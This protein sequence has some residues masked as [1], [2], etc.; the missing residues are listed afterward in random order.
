MAYYSIEEQETVIRYDSI[1]KQWDIYTTIPKHIKRLKN[2]A[3][4]TLLQEEKDSDGLTIA[5]R[6]TIENLPNSYTF[7][8]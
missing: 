4:A 1:T 3:I 5:Y 2:E 6:I 8:R 7:N